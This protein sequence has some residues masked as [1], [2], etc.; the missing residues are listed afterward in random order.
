VKSVINFNLNSEVE[1][2]FNIENKI[3]TAEKSKNKSIV[4]VGNG[5]IGK[6]IANWFRLYGY[7]NV[8][9]LGR[10]DAD[11]SGD[12]F[13]EAVGSAESLRRCIE[14]VKSGGTIAC[15]GNPTVDFRLEQK[16]YWQILRKQIT[17]KGSWNS[18][19]PSD[20]QESLQNINRLGLD[21]IITHRFDFK[22]A[23]KAFDLMHN[24]TEK[25][26]K[27]TVKI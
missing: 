1:S 8:N 26:G 17:L 3:E 25:Y 10:A 11:I 24:K 23:D 5:A 15:V 6:I 13:V 9:L 19:Y 12:I 4:I 14:N 27:V 21:E 16:T 22:D 18:S 2:D 7:G 20:W